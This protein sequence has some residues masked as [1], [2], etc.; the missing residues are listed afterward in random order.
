MNL[1]KQNHSGFS[2][3]SVLTDYLIAGEKAG[4][5][6]FNLKLIRGIS[7]GPESNHAIINIRSKITQRQ[8]FDQQETA[9]RNKGSVSVHLLYNA[10]VDSLKCHSQRMYWSLNLFHSPNSPKAKHINV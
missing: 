8:A 9:I 3:C 2:F 4:A 6:I 1:S 7:F 10:I 5:T